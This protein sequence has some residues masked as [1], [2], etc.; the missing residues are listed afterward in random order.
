[1]IGGIYHSDT[2]HILGRIYVEGRRGGTEWV[3]YKTLIGYG[4]G[5]RVIIGSRGEQ[6][7]TG[8][9][10]SSQQ[11]AVEAAKVRASEIVRAKFGEDA[12]VRWD[13]V[14]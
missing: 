3:P 6:L 4:V 2:T 11:A 1:M 5:N 13:V 12:E 8:Q 10:Y 7:Y 9:E 14:R